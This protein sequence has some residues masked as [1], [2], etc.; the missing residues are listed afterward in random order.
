MGEYLR[1]GSVQRKIRSRRPFRRGCSRG[2]IRR[3]L[4][5][6]N[7]RSTSERGENCATKDLN[8]WP[9]SA[10]RSGRPNG[11]K[12]SPTLK[13]S[14]STGNHTA[15]TKSPHREN[16]HALWCLSRQTGFSNAKPHHQRRKPPQ[17][18]RSGSSAFSNRLSPPSASDSYFEVSTKT[19]F[20]SSGGGDC[21]YTPM[22]SR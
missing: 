9:G 1:D 11:A 2:T 15:R 6:A 17:R 20:Q 19:P 21:S 18:T 13:L 4:V 14:R 7:C 8:C 3:Q 5:S 22:R 16:V 12:R 10:W